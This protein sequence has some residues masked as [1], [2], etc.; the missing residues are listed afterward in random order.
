MIEKRFI[1][2]YF[3]IGSP[4]DT[5]NSIMTAKNS[6]SQPWFNLFYDDLLRQVKKDRTNKGE[7]VFDDNKLNFKN[8]SYGYSI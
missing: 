5:Q 3:M 8:I 2:L 4:K 7:N 1:L 6:I